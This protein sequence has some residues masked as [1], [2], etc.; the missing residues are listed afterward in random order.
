MKCKNCQTKNT[1]TM[2]GEYSNC[3]RCKC[4]EKDLDIFNFDY[5]LRKM[6]FNKIKYNNLIRNK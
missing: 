3:I 1:E 2:S 5:P 4:G 6:T